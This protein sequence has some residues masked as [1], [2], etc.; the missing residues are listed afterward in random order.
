MPSQWPGPRPGR[1]TVPPQQVS[2]ERGRASAK[3]MQLRLQSPRPCHPLSFKPTVPQD[4][5]SAAWFQ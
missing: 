5:P 2:S 4:I 1:H 3:T